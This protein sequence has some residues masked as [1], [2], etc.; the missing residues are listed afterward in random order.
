M[1]LAIIGTGNVGGTLGRLWAELGHDI[2]YGVRD[3][4]AAKVQSLLGESGPRAQAM[5]IE[6]AVAAGQVV[7]LAVPWT[8]AEGVVR[9]AGSWSNKILVDATNPIVPGLEL[10]VGH[11]TSAAEEIAA[12]SVDARVVK[13]FNTLGYEHL[14]NPMF[15]EHT[16]NMFVCGDDEEA[17]FVVA[18]LAQELGFEV[19]DAGPL[20][21]ARL[22]EPLAMLWIRLAMVEGEGREIAFKLLHR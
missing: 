22:L 1:K 9:R 4:S 13:A 15:G 6:E 16:L 5:P 11:T 8:V 20:G 18:G 19:V 2:V 3:P 21:A 12:W 10:A 17:K 14:S 7:V